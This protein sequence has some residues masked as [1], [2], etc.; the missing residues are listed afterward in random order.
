[1]VVDR[2]G[3]TFAALSDPTRRAMIERAPRLL[4]LKD[5]GDDS[6]DSATAKSK[7]KKTVLVVHPEMDA[8][9]RYQS[10]IVAAGFTVIIARDLTTALLAMTHHCIELAIISVDLKDSGEGW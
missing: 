7:S 9:T 5:K 10:A 1:M 6:D 3:T 8:L 4:S 2:L